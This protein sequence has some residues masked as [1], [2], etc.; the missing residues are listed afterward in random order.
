[1]TELEIL[2]RLAELPSIDGL[3]ELRKRL[4]QLNSHTLSERKSVAER[5]RELGSRLNALLFHVAVCERAA[6]FIVG[7]L[8]CGQTVEF[9]GA[10]STSGNKCAR[11]PNSRMD[12]INGLCSP[13]MVR[14][15][16]A[17]NHSSCTRIFCMKCAPNQ[18]VELQCNLSKYEDE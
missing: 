4:H 8:Q 10:D 3:V 7:C 12:E 6:G 18:G 5:C 1:M 11:W 14:V 2:D 17:E 9:T 15:S 16:C 13:S